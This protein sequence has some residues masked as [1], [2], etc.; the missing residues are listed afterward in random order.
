M[1]AEYDAPFFQLNGVEGHQTCDPLSTTRRNS[2]LPVIAFVNSESRQ[3][4]LE[5]GR[6]PKF[7][8]FGKSEPFGRDL[9]WVRP[10]QDILHLNWVREQEA[11]AQGDYDPPCEV[12]FF[13]AP[14]IELGM[15][16]SV[17]ADTI[18]PFSLETL[19]EGYVATDDPSTIPSWIST[20]PNVDVLAKYAYF[21][22]DLFPKAID[23][24]MV[25]VS[26]LIGR[27]AALK[28]G[29]FGLLRDAPVQMVNFNDASRLGEFEALSKT[30]A[31]GEANEP[32][33]EGLFALFKTSR[34]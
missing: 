20:E 12:P 6:A 17:A 10:S 29:L 13:L 2:Q 23:V 30:P 4:A 19:F 27:D 3:V 26:L 14:V 31:P 16:P 5:N 25:A 1:K 7:M 15:R 34:L 21:R 8:L 22:A 9:K 33:V 18:H 28:S 32:E 11:R 24:V